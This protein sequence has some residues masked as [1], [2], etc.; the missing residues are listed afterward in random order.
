M[1]KGPVLLL[2]FNELVPSIMERF[3]KE[4]HI[5]HFRALYESSDVFTTDAATTDPQHLEPWVQWVTIHAGVDHDEHGILQL[6][7]GHKYSGKRVWDVVFDAGLAAWICGSMNVH[8]SSDVRG[9]VLPD[10]W[11]GGATAPVPA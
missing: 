5:P 10:P 7:E 6:S 4:G 9:C 11:S 2:E 3:M 8:C 1:K